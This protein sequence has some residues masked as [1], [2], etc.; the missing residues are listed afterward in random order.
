M[1]SSS[2]PPAPAASP[3]SADA[4]SIPAVTLPPGILPIALC[5]NAFI[6]G[7]LPPRAFGANP[8]LVTILHQVNF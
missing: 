5:K 4:P 6:P 2:S 3:P 8:L 1:F 7:V